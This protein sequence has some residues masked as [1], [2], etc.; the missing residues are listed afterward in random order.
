M[1]ERKVS[2]VVS[3]IG[4][5]PSWSHWPVMVVLVDDG[6]GARVEVYPQEVRPHPHASLQPIA[7]LDPLQTAVHRRHGNARP[8]AAR[9]GKTHIIPTIRAEQYRVNTDCKSYA[10]LFLN[11]IY[12]HSCFAFAMICMWSG[13]LNENVGRE[14][15]FGLMM[16]A[17]RG[18][19][20]L[21]KKD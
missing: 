11:I 6:D 9:F 10:E 1:F 12:F 20:I 21:I 3:S 18:C 8:G 15:F 19:Y 5:H 4:K 13:I 14:L 17:K 16:S 7:L 2:A